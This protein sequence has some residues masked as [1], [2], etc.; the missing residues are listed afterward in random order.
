MI[1]ILIKNFYKEMNLKMS[2]KKLSREESLEL[3]RK[4]KEGDIKAKEDLIK[5]YD[6]LIKSMIRKYLKNSSLQADMYSEAV[7]GLL[8]SIKD[9]D[10]SK[11]SF[12]TYAY[13]HILKRIGLFNKKWNHQSQIDIKIT[14]TIRYL[15]NK[16]QR[17]PTDEEI[18][19]ESGYKLITIQRYKQRC[20]KEESLEMKLTLYEEKGPC[21]LGRNK[22]IINFL[23]KEDSAEKDTIKKDIKK[24]LYSS[25]EILSE[26]EKDIVFSYLG[27]GKEE[28]KLTEIAARY[29]ENS[30]LTMRRVFDRAI[31]KVRI[32]L[33]KNGYSKDILSIY[34]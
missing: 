21:P 24:V 7:I 14:K 20:F 18:A 6:K 5:G 22:D 34:D 1:I 25:L 27:I 15:T 26:R 30:Y 23:S 13:F 4:A 3:V 8:E 12:V 28:E 29:N 17:E 11:A 9:Y 2:K 10:E 16:L 19:E 33:E 31:K 32:E